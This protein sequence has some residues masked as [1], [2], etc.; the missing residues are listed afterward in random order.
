M[1][2]FVVLRIWPKTQKTSGITDLIVFS[3]IP[4]VISE[5]SL[6]AKACSAY[7]KRSYLLLS[8]LKYAWW[9]VQSVQGLPV[10]SPDVTAHSLLTYDHIRTW[11]LGSHKSSGHF[12]HKND[13]LCCVVLPPSFTQLP[14]FPLILYSHTGMIVISVSM[15]VTVTLPRKTKSKILCNLSWKV[16]FVLKQKCSI[17]VFTENKNELGLLA[18]NFNLTTETETHESLNSRPSWST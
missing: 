9:S 2:Y 15:S 1:L 16:L 7:F 14:V 3:S 4:R 6:P 10:L 13:L 5:V 8:F 18:H 11:P 12:L 17:T